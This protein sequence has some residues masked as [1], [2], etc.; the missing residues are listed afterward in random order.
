M[1]SCPH[2]GR[3]AKCLK[4]CTLS[5]PNQCEGGPAH[6]VARVWLAATSGK[7]DADGFE[8][9]LFQPLHPLLS[10]NP[11]HGQHYRHRVAPCTCEHVPLFTLA[12]LQSCLKVALTVLHLSQANL[13]ML[14]ADCAFMETACE[15]MRALA[16]HATRHV[17]AQA[18]ANQAAALQRQV[19]PVCFLPVQDR[20]CDDCTSKS[21]S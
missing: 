7:A 13:H 6:R 11:C 19:L 20:G 15:H 3:L 12:S 8:G 17:T 4:S 5:Q 2:L 18:E 16:E 21:T 9:R 14:Q 10:R 1:L